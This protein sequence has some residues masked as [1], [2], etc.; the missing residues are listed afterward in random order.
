MEP[1]DGRGSAIH[2]GDRGISSPV[3]GAFVQLSG[4]WAPHGGRFDGMDPR[5][6]FVPGWRAAGQSSVMTVAWWNS[7]TECA[8]MISIC[9]W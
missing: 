5:T 2:R 7:F 1:V 9:V 8:K 3:E 6:G 4:S